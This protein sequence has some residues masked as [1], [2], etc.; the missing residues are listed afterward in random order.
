MS[1]LKNV[2]ICLSA[3]VFSQYLSLQSSCFYENITQNYLNFTNSLVKL[4]YFQF[5]FLEKKKH[6]GHMSVLFHHAFFDHVLGIFD[7]KNIQFY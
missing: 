5:A 1:K 4:H 2:R 3:T 6:N 7:P